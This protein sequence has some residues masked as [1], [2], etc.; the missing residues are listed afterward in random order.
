[1]D[2]LLAGAALVYFDG[3][4]TEAALLV[5]Q[6]ARQLGVPVRCGSR[7]RALVAGGSAGRSRPAPHLFSS[8]CVPLSGCSSAAG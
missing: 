6:R 2:E 5:A 1:M 4:L 7:R 3:R 8:G